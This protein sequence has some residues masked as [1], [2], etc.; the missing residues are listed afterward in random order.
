M[1]MKAALVLPYLILARTTDRREGSVNKLLQKRLELWISGDFDKLFEESHALKKRNR[2]KRKLLFNETKELNRQMN[3]GKVA[4]SIR[5]FQ[6]EQNGGVRDLQ[7][8]INGETVLQILKSKHPL[9]QPYDPALIVDDSPNTLPYL[10]LIFDR[11]EAHA[12]RRAALKTSGG[13]GR[14][15]CSRCLGMAPVSNGFWRSLGIP[16]PNSSKNSC[17]TR[18]RGTRS[19]ESASLQRVS[20][21]TSRQV[22][23]CSSNRCWGSVSAHNW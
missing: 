5:R 1:S 11:I 2:T 21:N 23:Q 17:K 8:K 18:V 13:H 10:P 20:T 3:P 6:N 4:N 19:N 7:E 14:T 15:I 22:S 16:L 9:T 12:I